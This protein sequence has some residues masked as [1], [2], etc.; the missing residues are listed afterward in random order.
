MSHKILVIGAI[1]HPND[2]KT[3]G[4]TTTLMQNFLDF[5]KGRCEVVHI[6]TFRFRNKVLNLLYFVLK[7]LWGMMITDMVMYNVSING[8]FSLFY[9]TA[10]L[11]YAL[12]KNVIFRKYG[13]SFLS[14]LEGC[15]Q[16]KRLKMLS[17][18]N[19]A[20]IVYFETKE[21][22]REGKKVFLYP[23]RVK[24]FPNCRKPYN[25]SMGERIFKKRF[26]FV[27]HVKEEKGVDLILDVAER[28]PKGY[29]IEIYGSIQSKKYSVPDFFVGRRV[30]Y[31]G[32][33]RSEEVLPTL[34]K[35]DV[36]LLPTFWENEGYPGIIIEA[37][38][39]GIPSIATR[40]RGIPELIENGKNGLL[41][42]PHDA[43]A[44]YEA[45]I[46]VTENNYKGFSE[47][48]MENYN[49]CYNSD[50][51]NR[52]ILSEMMGL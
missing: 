50:V 6:D 1:P 42:P 23:E 44:L 27:S 18:L 25:E 39:L 36:L 4:G 48:A 3:Y 5:A 29:S 47:K 15:P 8:A 28:L 16:R 34:S 24:W 14:Q 2:L 52:R 33:L 49:F 26:V 45:I 30:A 7:F 40:W 37:M 12:Q 11:A 19:R 21:M 17:L 38:S 32:A 35:Y 13:G 20:D 51:V 46:S 22:V 10:P 9:Y 41:I 31:R 43:D